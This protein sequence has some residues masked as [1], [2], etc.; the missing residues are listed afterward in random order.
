MTVRPAR[1][2]PQ[3]DYGMQQMELLRSINFF[4]SQMLG[5]VPVQIDV[6]YIYQGFVRKATQLWALN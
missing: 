3:F 1:S 4:R 6:N 2:S 5:E